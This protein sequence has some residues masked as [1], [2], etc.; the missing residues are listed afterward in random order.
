MSRTTTKS[1]SCKWRWALRSIIVEK[2]V[3]MTRFC[4][5]SQS[6]SESDISGTKRVRYGGSQT[7]PFIPLLAFLGCPQPPASLEKTSYALHTGFLALCGYSNAFLTPELCSA[8]VPLA[9]SSTTSA[10]FASCIV[11]RTVKFRYIDLLFAYPPK[12]LIRPQQMPLSLPP[13]RL[14]RFQD[15]NCSEV[16]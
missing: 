1:K 13:A 15:P 3:R 11:F 12:S 6:C 5:K 10:A 16:E 2:L 9:F 7:T 8:T 4:R 14:C